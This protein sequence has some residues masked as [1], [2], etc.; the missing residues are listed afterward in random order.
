[1]QDTI[2]IGVDTHKDAH[3]A[4]AITNLGAR[5][6]TLSIPATAAG[7]RKL[8]RWANIHGAVQAYGIEGTGSYGAGLFRALTLQGYHVIEVDR[9]NRRLRRQHGKNDTIDAEA[10]ARAVLS[11]E[12]RTRPKS[13]DGEVEM[14]RQLK[15]VRD[16]AM[17]A[18]SQAMVTLKTLLVN[19]PQLLREQFIAI[20]GRMTLIRALAALRPG[21]ITSTTASA[22]TA[23]R[24]LAHR[25][26]ALDVEIREL[27]HALET[28]VRLRAPTLMAAPGISTGTIAEMLI[29]LGDN[30][31]RIRSEAAFAKLCGVCPIPASS[32]KTT[33]HRLNRGGNRQAN[34]ALHR[35]AVVRMRSHPSTKTYVQRRTAEGK[36][37]REIRRC[38]KRYIAREIFNNLCKPAT[39]QEEASNAA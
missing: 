15:I 29:V 22:K 5:L 7:Y 8:V 24:M 3:V 9:P 11:G 6:G 1:M 25:W 31:E 28:L 23:L 26:L 39:Q 12:A 32:G 18:R 38:L 14:I 16:T 19:A 30:P 4:I 27:D 2:I 36:S 33:R 20:T 17:K 13:G 34:A 37:R 10:A 21:P 35:V